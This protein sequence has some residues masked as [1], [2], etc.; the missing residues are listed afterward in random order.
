MGSD[1]SERRG[2]DIGRQQ[3]G[4]VYAKA[5]L[6]AMEKSGVT[7]Q[8]MAEFD[9]LIHDVLDRF[10]A[11]DATLSS[12]RVSVE[13]KNSLLDRVFGAKMSDSLLTF[14]K[15]VAGRGRLDCLREIHDQA[16]RQLNE[17]RGLVEVHLTT[18]EPVSSALGAQIADALQSSLGRK[19]QL[20][21]STDP[22][23][24]GG[25]VVRV[26]DKVFDGSVVNQLARLRAETLEKTVQEM[27]NA[28]DRF[29]AAD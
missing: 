6:G 9:S 5:F 4:R 26:G 20:R 11:L 10:P 14:L 21:Q 15:V 7:D 16:R 1:R 12:P 8:C 24:I 13:E 29:A 23:L 27:R 2:A 18:V 22:D 17:Q 28:A 25:M 19:V 3:L